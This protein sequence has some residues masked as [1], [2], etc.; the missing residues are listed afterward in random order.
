MNNLQNMLYQTPPVI[1]S[2]DDLLEG[3]SSAAE[4]PERRASIRTRF[5]D[6]LRDE[7]RPP[8]PSLEVAVEDRAVVDGIYERWSITYP[9]GEDERAHAYLGLPLEAPLPVPGVVVLHGTTADGPVQTAGLGG[10]PERAFLDQL[11]RR[12]F[13]VL[14]PEHFVS[15]RRIPPEG[16]YHTKQFY[17][18]HPDWTAVG[19][20]VF[21]H[22]IA[23]DVLAAR[24]EVDESRLGCL[25]HSLGGHGSYFLAAYDERIRVAVGNCAGPTFR[26]NPDVENW[27]RGAWYVYFAHLRPLILERRPLPLDFHEI[28]SLI[29]PR[30]VLDLS[31]LNDGD[32]GC[33]RQ[34]VLMLMKV[35]ELYELLGAPQDCGFFVHGHGHAIPLESRELIAGFLSARLK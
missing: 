4:W 3:V 33:Q 18:K 8:R 34:R 11:C 19:K 20:S 16:P 7:A 6:L 21:E 25:G 10:H 30:A 2:W 24:P 22:S 14:A 23:L 26:H 27:A 32:L 12:G 29:A 13:A 15:G 1:S 9:V 35:A 5:L 17:E 28:L 31:G